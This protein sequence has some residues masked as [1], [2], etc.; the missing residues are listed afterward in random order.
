MC[1]NHLKLSRYE[2]Q[3]NSVLNND[4]GAPFSLL[5]NG[6][7]VRGTVYSPEHSF[8]GELSPQVVA[9]IATSFAN[10][11]KYRSNLSSPRIAVGRDTRLT[12]ELLANAALCGIQLTGAVPLCCGIATTPA[13][14]MSTILGEQPCDGAIMITASHMPSDK[15]GMKFFIAGTGVSSK[16]L[17]EILNS[18]ILDHSDIPQQQFE[19]LDI[20]TPYAAH[21]RDTIAQK[22]G[23]T[24]KARPLEGCRICVDAGGGAGGFFAHEVLA[25]LGADVSSSVLLE[26]DGSFSVHIPNPENSA[27][28]AYASSAVLKAGADLGIVFDTDVD[29]AAAI[30]SDGTPISRNALIALVGSMLS[31]QYSAAA[32]VT[33]SVTSDHLTRF[34]SEIGVFH[35][36]FRRGYRNVIDEAVRLNSAGVNAQAA[37]E[38]SGHC[39]FKENFFLD[40][41][42]YLSALIVVELCLC[43]REGKSL[44][45]SIEKLGYPLESAEIKLAVSGIS[46][47]QLAAKLFVH[48]AGELEKYPDVKIA[49][50]NHEGIRANYL[51]GWFLLRSSL[52]DPCLVL[53]IESDTAG[54]I[55][56]TIDLLTPLIR[57]ENLQPLSID[58]AAI[59]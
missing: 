41:G 53:N 3:L 42:A 46:A 39:A 44:T 52:H 23:T 48:I 51:D 29:R 22:L 2:R 7:D 13:M 54:G 49:T 9:S 21:L 31:K 4:I 11:I 45:Q 14:F 38:T 37:I 19:K 26:P 59:R 30:A 28:I 43:R 36:R 8:Y 18:S 50:P 17:S 1:I 25:P 35:H 40:D 47:P 5:Q 24:A 16:E 12:G 56:R 57:H 33:D 20:M 6:S 15:N 58:L 10:F 27:A 55:E 34:L 32:I